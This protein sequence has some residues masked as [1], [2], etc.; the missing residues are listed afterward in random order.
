M[1]I[2]GK[3]DANILIAYEIV[4]EMDALEMSMHAIEPREIFKRMCLSNDDGDKND[5]E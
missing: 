3:A 5:K 4:C 1:V 2:S